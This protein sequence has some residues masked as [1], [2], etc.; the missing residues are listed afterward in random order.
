MMAKMILLQPQQYASFHR[1]MVRGIMEHVVTDITKH[2]SGER[3]GRKAPKNEQE[4]AVKKKCERHA[5]TGRHNESSR[6]VWIIVMHA[7]NDV[8]QPFS[9]TRFGLVM[10]NISVD[11]IFEQRPEEHT[12]QKK[13]HDNKRRGSLPPKRHVK[14]RAHDRQVENQ[15]SRRMH[16]R[17][18]FHE[19]A[20]EHPDRFVFRRDVKGRLRGRAAL[21]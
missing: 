16:A 8:V 11:Q 4:H 7:V 17:K 14:H 21:A 20:V 15:W 13:S 6:I 19:I 5:D 18:E 2:Q 12:E 1:K 9:N 10:E 3:T